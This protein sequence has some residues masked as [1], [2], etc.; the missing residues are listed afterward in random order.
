MHAL[1]FSIKWRFTHSENIFFFCS[2]LAVTFNIKEGEKEVQ[3]ITND[4]FSDHFFKK[5]NIFHSF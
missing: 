3:R 1:T 2:R 5:V 4:I